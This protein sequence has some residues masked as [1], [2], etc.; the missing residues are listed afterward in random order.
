MQR[1]VPIIGFLLVV[2]GCVQ[3]PA[4]RPAATDALPAK[5]AIAKALPQPSIDVDS[6]AARLR[7]AL[8]SEVPAAIVDTPTRGRAWIALSQAAVD[9]SNQSIDRPQILVVVDRN[10]GVQQLRLVLARPDAAWQ[11]D[12]ALAV[13]AGDQLLKAGHV[14]GGQRARRAARR[15]CRRPEH[16]GAHRAGQTREGGC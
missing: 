15:Q 14:P 3:A 13:P 2:A 4:P 10:P 8:A 11:V 1:F 9:D 7:A 6:E 5:P 16:P 12:P